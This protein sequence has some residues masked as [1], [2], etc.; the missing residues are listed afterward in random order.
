MGAGLEGEHEILG[1]DNELDFKDNVLNSELNEELEY[2]QNRSEKEDSQDESERD[3]LGIQPCI[4]PGNRKTEKKSYKVGRSNALICRKRF[5]GKGEGKE[6]K[7]T[8]AVLLQLQ[9]VKKKISPKES[10][11]NSRNNLT[12]C[13]PGKTKTR[14]L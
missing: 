5:W 12:V 14:K 3:D 13:S 4:E 1:S 2:E 8:Q 6:E 7:Q 10:L 9:A 11:E